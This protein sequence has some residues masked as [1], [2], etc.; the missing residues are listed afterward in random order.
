VRDGNEQQVRVKLGELNADTVRNA[1]RR[2]IKRANV[3][4]SCL[5]NRGGNS[6]FL[7]LRPRC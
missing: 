2:W 6:L 1:G 5:V 7:T 4:P 3:Q